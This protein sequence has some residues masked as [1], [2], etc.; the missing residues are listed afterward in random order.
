MTPRK[1]KRRTAPRRRATEGSP[2]RSASSKPAR[3][4]LSELRPPIGLEATS[5]RVVEHQHTIQAFNPQLPAVL[6]TP[7]MIGLMENASVRAITP[8]LSLIHI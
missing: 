5:E 4:H 7:M 3:E 1:S 2:K 8:E 6:S